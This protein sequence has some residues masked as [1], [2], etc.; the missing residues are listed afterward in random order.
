VWIHL[1]EGARIALAS[2]RANPLRTLLTLLGNVVGMMCV[3]AVVSVLA[4]VDRYVRT[5]IAREGSNTLVL[6]QFDLFTFFNDFEGFAT[7][8]HNPD[9]TLADVEYLR[10]AA[11]PGAR[12]I[13][14]RA[15]AQTDVT[16]RTRTVES[17]TV[18]GRSWLYAFIDD[19]R[20]A[21]GRHLTEAE[22]RAGRPVVVLG[23]Q[24]AERL[25]DG[26]NPLG[27]M[28][29]LGGRH[30]EVVGVLAHR[31]PAFGD[32]P[33]DQAIVPIR[34]FLKTFGGRSL[35]VPI[36]AT[37]VDALEPLTDEVRL[38]MRIRRGLKPSDRETFA[39]S[40]SANLVSL[41]ERISALIFGALVGVVSISLVV[42]GIVVMN[43]MLV[44]VT[45]RTRE[46]GLRKALGARR[47]DVT[48]QFLVEAVTLSGVG[49]AIG[50]VLG[51]LIAL[52]L[53][54]WSPLP[55]AVEAWSVA[56]GLAVTLGVGVVFGIYPAI[57]AARLDPTEALRHE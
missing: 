50:I 18:H 8:M 4:G 48:W 37:S 23:S 5:E 7:A 15:S 41:W 31:P 33:N 39:V 56:A 12:F 44:S 47:R 52:A 17:V 27:E 30:A 35:E 25:F 21:S 40:T 16:R 28:V 19:L 26:A 36:L 24:L 38:A 55:Y 3:I 57:K 1:G 11:L 46:I 49:G 10:D 43:I 6:R 34:S 14:A 9:I 54:T 29:R 2:L 22:D 32:D 51:F 13:G 42:G 53:A 20:I 45:E